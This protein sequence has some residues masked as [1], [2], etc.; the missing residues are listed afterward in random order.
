MALMTTAEVKQILRITETTYDSDIEA[1]LPMVEDDLLSELRETFRDGYVYRESLSD[2]EFVVGDS[3]TNDHITDDESKFVERGFTSGMD[4]VVEGG[5]SNAGLYHLEGATAG[6]LT[7]SDYGEFVAQDQDDTSDD[8]NIGMI[9][10]SRIKW[11]KALKPI[12][13][14]MIWWRI[15]NAKPDDVKSESIDDYSVTYVGSYAYPTQVV[16]GLNRFRRI[17]LK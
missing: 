13:A 5:H 8:H 11:P 2:L 4:I 17:G 9:R 16:K 6:A 15:R 1:F 14:Q 7:M 10:I 12:A 3:D